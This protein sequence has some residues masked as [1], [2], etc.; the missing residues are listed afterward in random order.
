MLFPPRYVL[1]FYFSSRRRLT[2][3]LSDWS[4][5]VCSSDL[6]S[7]NCIRYE[8]GRTDMGVPQRNSEL[9]WLPWETSLQT[10]RRTFVP[11]E[12][13]RTTE[14]PCARHS[15]I[16]QRRTIGRSPKGLPTGKATCR[17]VP[18]GATAGKSVVPSPGARGQS[19]VYTRSLQSS[20]TAPPG[21]L[22]ANCRRQKFVETGIVFCSER[23]LSCEGAPGLTGA[24]GR[25]ECG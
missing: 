24:Q 7:R 9:P 2:R 15:L 25:L 10:S 19:T 11:S 14:S 6:T 21:A 17:D 8:S 22:S 5:D 18:F 4:S 16:S 23:E 3:C 1:L 13:G 12:T 20:Q